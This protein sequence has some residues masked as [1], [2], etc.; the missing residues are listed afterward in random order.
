MPGIPQRGSSAS[1]PVSWRNI[2]DPQSFLGSR[3]VR[4][5]ASRG[6]LTFPL[7]QG[8]SPVVAW[9]CRCIPGGSCFW[10]ESGAVVAPGVLFLLRRR[11]RLLRVRALRR[12]QR[13]IPFR[14]PVSWSIGKLVSV[15]GPNF[16]SSVPTRGTENGYLH[17]KIY[18]TNCLLSDSLGLKI[19]VICTI[20]RFLGN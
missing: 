9:P 5:V 3:M 17:Y 19:S 4:P 18:R 14:F 1:S 11:W 7:I 12:L 15:S 8:W 6:W 20:V 13:Q 16:L 2:G 10:R